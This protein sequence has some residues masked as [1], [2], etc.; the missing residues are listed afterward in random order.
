MDL[1]SE[2]WPTKVRV[3][4]CMSGALMHRWAQFYVVR[5]AFGFP[6]SCIGC[7]VVEF[8]LRRSEITRSFLVRAGA[9]AYSDLS[10]TRSFNLIFDRFLRERLMMISFAS[11]RLFNIESPF[12]VAHYIHDV[13]EAKITLIN[14]INVLHLLQH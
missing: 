14:Y 4:D 13:K 11:V 8:S 1:G 6:N 3:I 12:Q 10:S 7:A 5:G 2:L 9:F